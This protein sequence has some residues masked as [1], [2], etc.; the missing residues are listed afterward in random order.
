VKGYDTLAGTSQ[1]TPHVAGVAAL[2]AGKGLT[3][4]QI[5]ECLKTQSSKHGSYDPVF[6][7][8]IV[9]ADS[10]T[11]NCNQTT[12]P[13]FTPGTG[14]TGGSAGNP[15]P[16]RHVTVTFKR[17]TRKKLAKRGTLKVT[18]KSDAKAAVKLR[19]VVRYGKKKIVGAGR[20]VQLAKAG[21][22]RPVL[23]LSAKSRDRL[24]HHKK[25]VVRVTYRAGSESGLASAR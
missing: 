1:A 22:R 19:V 25:A 9:D 24:R 8:G 16:K 12:T 21:T 3:A 6:G 11:K 2:L 23:K 18:V 15:K 17:T 4:G 7:Y 20:T 14:G 10:A 5:L 13:S